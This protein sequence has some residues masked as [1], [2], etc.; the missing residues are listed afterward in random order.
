MTKTILITGCSS[1]IGL[2]A[3]EK[4]QQRGYQVFATARKESDVKKL[5]EKGLASL[6]LD[7]NDSNSIKN[8][9]EKILQQ[10]H[11]T[12]DAVFN[13]AGFAVPGA[14][15]DITRDMMRTQFETNVFGTMELTNLILPIMRKQNHGRIIFNSSILGIV[16]MPFR[17]AY[18]A[19]KFAIEGFANT[20]R[21]E[22]RNSGIFVSIINPGPIETLFRHNAQKNYQLTLRDKES[23]YRDN[24]S[25]MEKRFIEP[26]ASEKHLTLGPNAVVKKLIHALESK[27]P[28]AHYFVG[29]PAHLFAVLRRVLPDG[30]LD[31]VMKLID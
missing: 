14:V 10:T 8:S 22:L 21:Q 26:D 28:K 29:F 16:T 24:Y 19:S 20:L 4:L 17:G 12:L 31:F 27:H 5:Q 2:C 13:N 6:H 3:A 9:L 15:E 1:G 11:G 30:G 23:Y 7:L 25:H 18:N